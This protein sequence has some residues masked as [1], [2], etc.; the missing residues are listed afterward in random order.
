MLVRT[1]AVL[2]VTITVGHSRADQCC[3]YDCASG[4]AGVVPSPTSPGGV[5]PVAGPV[6]H[7]VLTTCE[8]TRSCPTKVARRTNCTALAFKAKNVSC[9]D[10]TTCPQRLL[11]ERDGEH[12]LVSLLND[13]DVVF[14]RTAEFALSNGRIIRVRPSPPAR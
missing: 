14:V 1:L 8:T 7:A 9:S 10:R 12:L 5:R 11:A 2:I 13:R 4:G 3:Y 6:M